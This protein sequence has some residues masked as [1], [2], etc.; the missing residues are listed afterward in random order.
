MIRTLKAKLTGVAM[1]L[2]HSERLANPRDLATRKLKELTSRNRGKNKT[3][4][5]GDQIAEAEWRASMYVDDRGEPCM[6]SDNI[7]ACLKE[8]GR[9]TKQGKQILAA[10]FCEVPSFSLIYDGPRDLDSLWADGRFFDYRAVGVQ[11]KRVMR[12]R[13]CWKDWALEITLK[14]DDELVSPDDMIAILATAGSQVGLCE[15]RPQLG[16]FAVTEI[17]IV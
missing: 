13:P 12:A 14:F 1:L 4:E 3:D 8:G 7:L 17:E 10:V 6:P 16:R 5:L 2:V 11:G 9:K 15:K